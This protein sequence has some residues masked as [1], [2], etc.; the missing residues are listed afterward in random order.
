MR[1]FDL[2]LSVGLVWDVGLQRKLCGRTR[3]VEEPGYREHRI[4]F[5]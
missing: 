3:E 2:V 4:K 1:I 5:N